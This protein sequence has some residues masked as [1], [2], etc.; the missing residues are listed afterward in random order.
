MSQTT[1]TLAF[2]QWKAQQGATG[3]PVLLDEFVFAN[4]PGLDPDQPVDRNETLPPAEQIVHRQAVSRKGVVNDN[5]VVHSVV[6]GAD[7]G[8]FSFN[9]IGLLNKASGT[10]AMIVHAPLQQK[11]KTAEGQQG[12]VL[13]RSF[14]MEYNGAQAETGI[15]TPAETWQIDFTARMAGMD[16]RQRLENIDIFGAAAFF[17]DGYLVGKSGNQFYVTKG[18]G[19]VAGLRTTLAENLNITVTTRPVKVWLDVCWTGTLTSV[20]GVQSR[21]TVADN[22]ADYVQNDIQHY[23]FAVA[24]IDE[25][26]NI[27]D[28]R[29][30]GTLNEQQASDALRKHEQSRNHPD[31]TT[32]EK[33]FVQL[34]SETNS[35][36]EMLAATPKA[37]KAAMDN[38]NGRLEKNS[39]GGD[40]PDK[41]QFAR[42]IGA[43]TSTTI[44]LGESGWFKIATVVMPQSTSTA[45]IKLY[46]GSGYNVGSFE[47]AAISELVLRAGNG[48]P[49]GITA[50]LWRRSPSAAN[51]V[52]WVNTSGDTY[53]IYINIGQYAYWLIAQ[54]DY[55]GNANVTLHSTPEYS[56]VQP[57]NSTSG[58]TYTLYN[59]L[60]KPTPEDVGALS[61]N[62]G[63]L[64]GPLGIGTDNA[65][66]GNS[67]VFGDNDT[68]FKWHSDG[69]LGIYANN[70][71]VGY[72]DNSGLHMSV[73]VLTNGAVRAGNAKKLS[74]TSNNNSTMTAT[75]NLWGDANRPTVIELDDDQGWHLY[76]QRNPDGSIVFTVNGDITANTLR[77]GGAIY[78]NNGDV[79]GTVWGGGNAAWLSGY[80][81]SNMVKAVRLGPVA[82]SGG[83]WRDFQLGGGQVVT[84]FHTDGSWEM[85]GGDDKVYYRPI[86]YLVGDTW[87]TAP[88]V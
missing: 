81:Y 21:I 44:T 52:A 19:Y 69:V 2:E 70:A 7:V 18:T 3:E 57:G 55:T 78:A 68:G 61:V 75:F 9:W 66:G 42:T 74:L 64:N 58:Q 4:V 80:L 28:L 33:G 47:Q 43:V 67:I 37:V 79:S 34:S 77:A 46:G 8:D 29:P 13:T 51:E 26:G 27:T 59:S 30:K 56:S 73:D 62:G 14:L 23:V 15:N 20:W 39:N 12:N 40:I 83:L 48:S 50:T 38:A 82:L 25:N 71:L 24:G 87:V 88:S 65:L 10:L 84:G 17:G 53:D 86:Q 5:A 32:R 60:M 36:S 85:E 22:L 49:V 1:I 76:S 72:I 16:E 63:R 11:L 6:L 45:V 31:A 54:Y 35:D 41:K